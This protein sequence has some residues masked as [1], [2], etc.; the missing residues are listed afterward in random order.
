MAKR[1]EDRAGCSAASVGRGEVFRKLSKLDVAVSRRRPSREDRCIPGSPGRFYPSYAFGDTSKLWQ[2]AR[3]IGAPFTMENLFA[4][5]VQCLLPE[6]LA[7]F[8]R[9]GGNLV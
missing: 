4:T 9:V 2:Y 8:G 1:I 5:E 6:R 3:N 7:E